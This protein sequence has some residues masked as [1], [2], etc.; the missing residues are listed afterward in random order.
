MSRTA[1]GLYSPEIDKK[2]L[3]F[4]LKEENNPIRKSSKAIFDE[5]AL[6]MIAKFIMITNHTNRLWKAC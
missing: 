5:V 4:S 3:E 6:P 2:L 1:I